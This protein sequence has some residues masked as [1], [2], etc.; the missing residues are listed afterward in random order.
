MY[1]DVERLLQRSSTR[2]ERPDAFERNAPAR[3][4]VIMDVF[5][6]S[7]SLH[8]ALWCEMPEVRDF[9][10]HTAICVGRLGD[11]FERYICAFKGLYIFY[12]ICCFYFLL[13]VCFLFFRG[14]GG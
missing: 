7:G 13:L 8:R 5:G 14:G 2:R 3:R 10:L 12:G 11:T 1:E 9:H 6:K 4:S